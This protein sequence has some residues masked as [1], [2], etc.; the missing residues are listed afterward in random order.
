MKRPVILLTVNHENDSET[1]RIKRTYSDVLINVGALPLALPLSDDK[2]F[3]KESIRSAHGLL[4]TGGGDIAPELYGEEQSEKCESV[5]SL[6]DRTE[7]TL[8]EYAL[9]KRMPILGI[10]R[11]IQ[12]MN[13]ALGGTLYR[14][15]SGHM[16]QGGY[17][18][19]H[20]M[21]ETEKIL[22]GICPHNYAVNSFHHQ[23]VRVL[24]DELDVCARAYDGTTE[25]IY[26]PKYPFFVGVQW[27]PE[28]MVNADTS[29]RKLFKEFVRRCTEYMNDSK[30]RE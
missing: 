16:A 21:V 26:M 29:S 14:D 13:V 7:L 23:A 28:R 24:G 6:R 30:E 2:N 20:H 22:E 1:Y 5:S 11:G 17:D 25:G 18:K 3:L 9:E 15:I 27:H 10:C 4:L 19:V 8:I 12:V